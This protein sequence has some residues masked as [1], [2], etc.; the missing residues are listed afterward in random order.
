MTTL[1]VRTPS[2]TSEIG[3]LREV[4]V[5]RPGLELDR[6]TPSNA[7]ALLFDDVLWPSR[8]RA[9]HD[10]FVAT[11]RQQGAVV[12]HFDELLAGAVETSAG[13]D[14]VL[15]RTIT[16]ARFGDS[17]AREIRRLL[18]DADASTLARYLIGGIVKADLSPLSTG[19]LIWRAWDIEDFVLPPLPNTL[20]Q[21]DNAAWIGSGVTVNPM[22]MPARVR[23]SIN[24]R[25]VLHHH[26]RFRDAEFSIYYGDDDAEHSP[27]TLEGGDIHVLAPG[28]L[29]IGMGERTTPAG[30]EAL[31][32]TLF[33]A[34]AASRVLAI[35][36][37]KARAAMHLDTL[38][39][40]VHHATFVGYPNLDLDALRCWVLTA[41]QDGAEIEAAPRFGLRAAL[42]EVLGLERVRVLAADEDP[43][44]AEREQWND[45]DNYLTVAP[46]VVV[47]Y[48]RNVVT[49][50]MLRANGIEVLEIPGSELG[51]GRGGAR[52]MSCPVRRDPLPTGATP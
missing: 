16:E 3:P 45:A 20:F 32:R 2:V 44:A 26:P 42:A 46:G 15:D 30:V 24:T 1:D 48:D 11:L 27:A 40:M 22:A 31:T 8:A 38:L 41:D 19:S 7:A 47:G 4:I 37:P 5:H 28:V 51:R 17:L 29:M 14:F 43:R 35:E 34:G 39:T 36:L 52:C 6:L 23:E 49:N 13:R 25:A 50:S 18:A 33:A 12:H 9:E 21:R 10:I